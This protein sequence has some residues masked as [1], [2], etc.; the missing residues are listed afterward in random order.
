MSKKKKEETKVIS[1]RV[2]DSFIKKIDSYAKG[3]V[4]D[5]GRSLNINKAARRL[6]FEAL[7]GVLRSNFK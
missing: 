1:F 7:T 6:V 4:D 2:T 3:K 5:A